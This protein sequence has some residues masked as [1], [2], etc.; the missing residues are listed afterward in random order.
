MIKRVGRKHCGGMNMIMQFSP[1][2]ADRAMDVRKNSPFQVKY[3]LT[4]QTNKLSNSTQIYFEMFILQFLQLLPTVQQTSAKQ[5]LS[6][7][8]KSNL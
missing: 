8:K 5:F 2:G 4:F 7:L 3:I 1:A 6:D